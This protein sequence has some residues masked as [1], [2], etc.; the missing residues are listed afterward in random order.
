LMAA[1]V[2]RGHQVQPLTRGDERAKR[3]HPVII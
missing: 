2:S 3:G 1:L